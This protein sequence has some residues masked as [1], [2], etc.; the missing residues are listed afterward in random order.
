MDG[1]KD[2]G[3]K[4]ALKP[5]AENIWYALATIAGESLYGIN[6]DVVAKNQHYW[7]GYMA[8]L[9]SDGSREKLAD[10]N[11]EKLTLP[12]LSQ[13]EVQHV[14][15][16]LKS[17]GFNKRQLPGSIFGINFSRTRFPKHANFAGFVFA[18]HANF[19]GAIFAHDVSFNRAIFT[20][21]SSFDS[22]TFNQSVDFRETQFTGLAFFRDAE[23]KNNAEFINTKFLS[24]NFINTN[25]KGIADF[26]ESEFTDTAIFN[27][28]T[29]SSRALFWKVKFIN[30][31]NFNST[32]FKS[33][34]SFNHTKF[35]RQPPSFSDAMLS[36]DTEWN[37]VE[38]PKEPKWLQW[39]KWLLWPKAHNHN[40]AKK[41]IKIFE[42]LADMMRAS[43]RYHDQHQFFR[44]EMHARRV[45]ERNPITKSINWVYW[46]LGNYGFGYGRALF[47]WALNIIIGAICIYPYY[48]SNSLNFAPK[49]TNTLA[50]SFANCHSFLGLNRGALKGVYKKFEAGDYSTLVPFHF[51]WT[52]QA[53]LGIIFLF[54]LALTIRNRFRMR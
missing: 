37:G 27:N 10:F 17:R 16:V 26:K 12:L 14:H 42:R 11:G 38:W 35:Q 7:N 40:S 3:E 34:T 45:A 1:E 31:A 46:F 23:F 33:T 24:T 32:T 30:G 28:A 25:F 53:L 15:E 36:Q 6:F 52:V 41:N 5:A 4:Q 21:D 39:P 22:T 9:I 50:I 43:G 51:V 18:K 19:D 44:S 8:L 29:F 47:F 48:G 54:F 13:T 20:K 49:F 2:A